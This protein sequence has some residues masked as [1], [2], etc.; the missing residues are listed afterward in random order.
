MIAC[1]PVS[2]RVAHAIARSEHEEAA[3][4]YGIA[5][6]H[7]LSEARRERAQAFPDRARMEG[8]A[9]SVGEAGS[10]EGGERRVRV[11]RSRE[12]CH[13]AKA[14]Q[15]L[16]LAGA[17]DDEGRGAPVHLGLRGGEVSDLLTA[18]DSSEVT[19]EGEDDGPALPGLAERNC[20]IV[21][22]EDGECSQSCREFTGHAADSTRFRPAPSDAYNGRHPEAGGGLMT[23]NAEMLKRAVHSDAEI[24]GALGAGEDTLKGLGARA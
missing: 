13:L 10:P 19:D 16:R 15:V 20:A 1:E 14:L 9:P 12:S 2:P 24:D 18:E 11:E 23:S 4:L 6:S 22:V 7:A 3:L 21:F 5:S 17:D 8:L